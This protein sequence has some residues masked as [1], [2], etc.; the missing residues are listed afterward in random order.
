MPTLIELCGFETDTS[1]MDGKSLMPIIQNKSHTPNTGMDIVGSFVIVENCRVARKGKW[2]LYANPYDTSRRDYTYSEEFVLF[3][4]EN[5]PGESINLYD[6]QP[7]VVSE[8][9]KLY[10][11]WKSQHGT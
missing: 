2:K 6:R 10:E 7:Q 5:D 1:D 4:L 11:E 8:L 3:D 9:K